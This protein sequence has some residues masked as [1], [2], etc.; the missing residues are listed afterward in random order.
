MP[1]PAH[2]KQLNWLIAKLHA[3]REDTFARVTLKFFRHGHDSIAYCMS[4]VKTSPTAG[5][6]VVSAQ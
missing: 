1:A 2:S 4:L 6:V 3:V 5:T